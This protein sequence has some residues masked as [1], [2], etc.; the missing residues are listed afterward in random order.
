M[1]LSSAVNA[2]V[3]GLG[4][5]ARRAEIVSSNIANAATD[6]YA[7]RTLELR[8][9]PITAGVRA[10]TVQR[11]VDA[12]LLREFRSAGAEA[13]GSRLRAAHLF[14]I[15]AAYGQPGDGAGLPQS[16][17]RLD[18]AL[19]TAAADPSSPARLT[20]VVQATRDVARQFARSAAA[21]Q[22]AR[23]EADRQ[24]AQDVATLNKSLSRIERLEN[25]IVAVRAA[26]RDPSSLMDERQ[27]II[28]TISGIIP[29]IEQPR[30]A[31]RTTLV[32]RSGLVL[33]DGRAAQFAF[34]AAQGINA[35][36]PPPLS[37]LS[38]NGQPVATGGDGRIAG[39]TLMAAFALRDGTTPQLQADLD[40]LAALL[41]A[42]L[43]AADA[44]LPA[45]AAGLLTD[46]GAPAVTQLAGL[47]TRLA[48]N[49]AVDEDRGGALWRL[50]SGIGAASEGPA[51]DGQR[52]AGLAAAL[53][54]G[55]DA[56]TSRA[57]QLLDRVAGLRLSAER[58]AAQDSARAAT[59]GE[60]LATAG[61]NSDAEL[62]DL[63]QI[64]KAYAANA[65]VL[66]AIDDM[67][68]TLLGA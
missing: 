30:E 38:M 55:T 18:S 60:Q 64:E 58:D 10:G 33:F 16:L 68:N 21:I 59:L 53:S 17:A 37:G 49:P 11:D 12:N 6:G 61:V 51:G 1:S 35:T 22:T 63:M 36:Q 39:G 4:V 14:R 31:G 32:S 23:A 52:L 15:G 27:S 8:P 48:V 2:A 13:A 46:A 67:L 28:G 29:V 50:R 24:I 34:T 3:S 44:S 42:R 7:R 19:V 25:Q 41:V 57:A 66:Q 43:S 45:G 62:Q 40:S 20:D 9:N 5:T 26:G 54:T 56:P 65:R 47:S